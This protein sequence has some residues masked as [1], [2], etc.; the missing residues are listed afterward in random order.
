[1]KIV[2]GTIDSF[3][4]QDNIGFNVCR[5]M[6]PSKNVQFRVNNKCCA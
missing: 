4:E 5:K 2:V 3:I 1:M 6:C